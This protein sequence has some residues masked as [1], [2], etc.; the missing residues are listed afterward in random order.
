MKRNVQG[1]PMDDALFSVADDS[2]GMLQVDN[3]SNVSNTVRI[4]G[5][6][7]ETRKR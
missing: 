4:T 2:R 3:D 1:V 5:D 7:L 6:I